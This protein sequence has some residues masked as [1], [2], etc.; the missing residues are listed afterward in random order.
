MALVKFSDYSSGFVTGRNTS[1][2]LRPREL[3]HRTGHVWEP[4]FWTMCTITLRRIYLL[5][6][7]APGFLAAWNFRSPA[8]CHYFAQN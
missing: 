5:V 1:G 3:P 8:Q 4:F 6:V 7:H 2:D